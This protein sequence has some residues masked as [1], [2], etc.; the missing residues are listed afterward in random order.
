M[1]RS[2]TAI[3]FGWGLVIVSTVLWI[4]P[5][6][7]PFLPVSFKVKAFI[8][9]SAIV[10]AEILFWLGAILVGKEAVK[11]YKNLFRFKKSSRRQDDQKQGSNDQ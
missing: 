1:K 6:I 9:G 10:L 8:G 3:R 5:F 4:V 2:K 7:T 11:K